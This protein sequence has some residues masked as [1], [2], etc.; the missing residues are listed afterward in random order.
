MDTVKVGEFLK[1]LRFENKLTQKEVAEILIVTPQTISKW[2]L[3]TSLP[4][5]DMLQSLSQVYNVTVDE[6]I[7]CQLKETSQIEQI[8]LDAKSIMS[9]II[10]GLLFAIAITVYFVDYLIIDSRI[11]D[12]GID[13]FES[14]IEDIQVFTKVPMPLESWLVF[15]L[16]IFFP[17][18]LATL[19]VLDKRKKFL[20]WFHVLAMLL[21]LM[22]TLS[23]MSTPG[24]IAAELGLMLHIIYILFIVLS[25]IITISTFKLDIYQLFF[26]HQRECIAAS[27]MLILAIFLPSLYYEVF[28]MI[29]P[30]YIIL[31]FML[32][33]PFVIVHEAVNGINKLASSFYIFLSIIIIIVSLI[34]LHFYGSLVQFIYVVFLVIASYQQNRLNI[35]MPKFISSNLLFGTRFIYIQIAALTIY[36]YSYI[37]QSILFYTSES[38]FGIVHLVVL[39]D[40]VHLNLFLPLLALFVRFAKLNKLTNIFDSLWILWLAYFTLTLFNHYVLSTMYTTTISGKLL[41]IPAILIIPYLIYTLRKRIK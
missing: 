8:K 28:Y 35:I 30:Y 1:E 11:L 25:L 10:Y 20:L 9:Y 17:V 41:F 15:I 4:S 21:L 5:I 27:V 34:F 3:G 37:S 32:L 33:A 16:T 36:L 6:I 40:L 14:I 38:S 12:F 7:N 2:E 24:F 39:R 13:R 22:Y 18:L 19:Q 23:V 31:F 26:K 29:R